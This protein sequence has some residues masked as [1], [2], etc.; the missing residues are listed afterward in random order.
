MSIPIP[1]AE[2]VND[3]V[4]P[5]KRC[6]E[7]HRLMDNASLIRTFIE[8]V[9]ANQSILLANA[10]L[11]IEPVGKTLQL[12][13]K[14]ERMIAKAHL[15]VSILAIKVKA[16]TH[17]RAILHDA[18]LTHQFLPTQPDLSNG[19]CQYEWATIPRGYEVCYTDGLLFLQA[20][21][22]HQQ[23]PD[24]AGLLGILLWHGKTWHPIRDIE[25]DRGLIKLFIWGG[26]IPLDPKDRIVWLLRIGIDV[27]LS[28]S[29]TPNDAIAASVQTN[30]I[31]RSK[32]CIGNYLVEAGLLST[33]QVDVI[34]LDQNATGMRFGEIVASRGWI[35]EQT[36]EYLMEHLIAPQQVV[37]QE[38]S[39]TE[40][41]P[42]S[43]PRRA[44]PRKMEPLPHSIHDRATFIIQTPSEEDRL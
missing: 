1:T 4:S 34:L 31:L 5:S 25:C 13:A 24:R 22:H 37:V 11:R 42:P 2:P 29:S 32:K 19:F 30:G 41:E 43:P 33:A 15:N 28:S 9:I 39:P 26:Q 16:S 7:S 6:C 3:F 8:S 40:S 17:Q 12:W 27:P 23:H 21:W 14:N 44:T 36:I 35:K 10:E 18:L 20:W 38:M